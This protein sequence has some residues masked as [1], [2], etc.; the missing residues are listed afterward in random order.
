[1]INP[2]QLISKYCKMDEKSNPHKNVSVVPIYKCECKA[3]VRRQETIIYSLIRDN[4]VLKN[5][6][7]VLLSQQ[8]LHRNI[9]NEICNK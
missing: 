3:K 4:K 8:K 5:D 6:I 9:L 2:A 1:M 7:I